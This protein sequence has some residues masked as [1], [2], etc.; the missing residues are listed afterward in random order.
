MQQDGHNRLHAGVFSPEW[1]ELS[2]SFYVHSEI[3]SLDRSCIDGT[4]RF[5][6]KLVLMCGLGAQSSKSCS[7]LP[8]CTKQ[9]QPTKASIPFEPNAGPMGTCSSTV[10]C[11]PC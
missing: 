8:F 10:F 2:N 6:T 3:Q 5:L 4:E 1:N 11:P 9:R 7:M